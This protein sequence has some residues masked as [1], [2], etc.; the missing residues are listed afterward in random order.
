MTSEVFV[1]VPSYNHAPYIEKCLSSIFGQTVHP[2]KLLVIDDGSTDGSSQIIE[3]MLADCSFDSEL[4]VRENR[5]LCATLNQALSLSDGK[6]FAYLG[7]DDFWLP[8]FIEAREKLLENNN[9]AVLGYGHAYF[10]DAHGDIFEST[11]E[12]NQE[13]TSHPYSNARLLL[14]NGIAP[15]S[16]TVVY[17][18]SSL[19][20][21]SWNE[22]SLLEDYE[23]YLKLLALGEFAFDPAILSAWRLHGSNVSKNL[24]MMHDEVSKAHDSGSKVFDIG[25]AELRKV[26]TK[27]RFRQAQELLQQGE[28]IAAIRLLSNNWKGADSLPQ[29]GKS[30]IHLVFPKALHA[31]YK[32]KKRASQIKY[33]R[34]TVM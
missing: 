19:E 21:V 1:V 20:H 16:S 26:Q 17:R 31:W 15:I 18:R 10:V 7:S 33:Y 4:I 9:Y 30:L 28:K 8:D 14:L 34:G 2:K 32:K 22:K 6:Y 29:V 12:S 25:E 23:I 13:W 3:K 24:I 5:G 11:T 27:I